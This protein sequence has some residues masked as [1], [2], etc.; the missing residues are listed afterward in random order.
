MLRAIAEFA[1]GES[2]V[3]GEYAAAFR[4]FRIRAVREVTSSGLCV[5]LMVSGRQVVSVADVATCCAMTLDADEVYARGQAQSL[6]HSLE[7]MRLPE[8]M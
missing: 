1:A 3:H 7:P 6:S 8:V 5:K 2:L 4:G